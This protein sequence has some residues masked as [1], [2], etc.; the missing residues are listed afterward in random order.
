MRRSTIARTILPALL[1]QLLPPAGVRAE[2]DRANGAAS[3]IVNKE[4]T[5]PLPGP[6]QRIQKEPPRPSPRPLPRT[7]APDGSGGRVERFGY[8]A[9]NGFR[10]EVLAWPAE[11]GG[12][13]AAAT[14]TAASGEQMTFEMSPDAGLGPSVLIDGQVVVRYATGRDGRLRELTVHDGDRAVSSF[15][16][17]GGHGGDHRAYLHLAETLASRHSAEFLREMRVALTALDREAVA[18]ASLREFFE[19][20]LGITGYVV[21]VWGIIAGCVVGG[22]P[23]LGAS[24][25]FAILA[26]E[27]AV[28]SAILACFPD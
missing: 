10:I 21:S 28:A 13:T 18:P 3:G 2:P 16:P 24:C 20:A 22:V 7:Q 27:V 14:L 26:H 12:F 8:D 19:C 5:R 9:P 23:T 6:I 4:N 25:V 15:H 1:L 11:R 17:R